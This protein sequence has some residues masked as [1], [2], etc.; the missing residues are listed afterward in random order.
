MKTKTGKKWKAED[1]EEKADHTEDGVKSKR[2]AKEDRIDAKT[3]QLR[4]KHGEMYTG[5]Q[6]RLWAR[7]HLSGQHDS[8]DESPHI[9]LF[10]GST[11]TTKGSKRDS[12]REA[13]T[14][15]CCNSCGRNSNS[16]RLC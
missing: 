2:A 13:L 7:M 14:M 8:L 9:P 5:P 15:Q 10:T 12:L 4:E 6:F 1:S 11:S 16:Q 3:Q